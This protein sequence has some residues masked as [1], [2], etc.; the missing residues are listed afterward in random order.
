MM[1]LNENFQNEMKYAS[2]HYPLHRYLAALVSQSVK[3][4]GINMSDVLPS[5]ELLTLL[6]M[7]PMRVQ[8]SLNVSEFL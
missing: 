4:M 1:T 3:T 6:M 8:V 5:T 7:H 2:F